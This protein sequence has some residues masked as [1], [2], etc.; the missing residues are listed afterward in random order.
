M[1]I[2]ILRDTLKIIPENC[3]Y[4]NYDER[5]TAYIEE[6]LGLKKDGD[7]IKLVRKNVMDSFSLAYLEVQ[8]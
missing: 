6:V 7:F 8:K 5:D 2:Q 4:P 3:G 1:K